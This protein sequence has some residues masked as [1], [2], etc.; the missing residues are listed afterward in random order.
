[1]SELSNSNV[2]RNPPGF[3][4]HFGRTMVESSESELIQNFRLYSDYFLSELSNNG[5]C[6]NPP[7]FLYH[8]SRIAVESS[9]SE[10]MTIV[11]PFPTRTFE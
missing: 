11:Q 10:L 6:G 3:L 1:M 7:G 2:W 8:F 9:E 5:A 4:N